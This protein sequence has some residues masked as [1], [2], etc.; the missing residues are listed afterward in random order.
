MIAIIHSLDLKWPYYVNDYLEI[1]SKFGSATDILS[2]DCISDNYKF[3]VSKLHIKTILTLA[4]PFVLISFMF[5][6]FLIFQI[7]TRKSQIN[8]VYISFI[9]TSNFLQPTI[10]KVLFDNLSYTSLNNIPYLTKELNYRFDDASH[11]QWVEF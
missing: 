7:I 1:S 6:I 3:P 4:F 10:L 5:S 2:I 8:R 11:I 9:I